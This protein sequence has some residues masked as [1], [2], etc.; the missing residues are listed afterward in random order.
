MGP[1]CLRGIDEELGEPSVYE[2]TLTPVGMDTVDIAAG[3][4]GDEEGS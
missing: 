1:T 2:Y 4:G 3:V